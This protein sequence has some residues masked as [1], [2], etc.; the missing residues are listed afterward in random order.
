M[1]KLRHGHTAQSHFSFS[2]GLE[3]WNNEEIITHISLLA[4][5]LA[6]PTSDTGFCLLRATKFSRL[7]QIL[8][9][10]CDVDPT[11]S[12]MFCDPHVDKVMEYGGM[13]TDFR[14]GPTRIIQIFNPKL[15]KHTYHEVPSDIDPKELALLKQTYPTCLQSE[16][17]SSYWLSRF[18]EGDPRLASYAEIHWAF[19]IPE[20]PF[21]ALLGVLVL[22][23]RCEDVLEQMTDLPRTSTG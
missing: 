4:T 15:L 12:V 5:V 11:D 10:G 14:E 3:I 16:D 22:C 2:D 17:G 19:W 7:R 21:D 1:W 18:S 6:M 23:K 8:E 9:Y 13:V 20:N